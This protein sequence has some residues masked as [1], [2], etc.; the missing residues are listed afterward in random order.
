MVERITEKKR[1]PEPRETDYDLRMRLQNDAVRKR[2]EGKV[3]IKGKERPWQQ[4]R[5]SLSRHLTSQLEWDTVGAPGWNIFIQNI[6]KHSG[7]H[8]HQGGVVIFVLE[9][10]GYS[11]VEGARFDWEEDDLIVLPI[12]PGGCEHQHFNEDIQNPAVWIAFR[13]RPITDAVDMI[14]TQ[15]GEHPDWAG[16]KLPAAAPAQERKSP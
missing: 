15:Q 4:N 16:G 7:R 11:V 3:I 9:G 2:V 14:R 6:K 12:K 1:E 8:T 5:Q 10:K 13:F